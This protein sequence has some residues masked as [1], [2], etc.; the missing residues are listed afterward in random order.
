MRLPA[1]LTPDR[2]SRFGVL[3]LTAF[4]FAAAVAGVTYQL[5]GGLREEILR[6]EAE[7]LAGVASMQMANEMAKQAVLGVELPGKLLSAVLETSR[8]RGVIGVRVL[9]AQ[10]GFAGAQPYEWTDDLPAP[11]VWSRMI[12]DRPLA[13]LHR[14]ADVPSLQTLLMSQ[15]RSDPAVP[16]VEVWVP[17]RRPEGATLEGAA[18]FWMDGRDIAEE[19]AA[20]D[21]RLFGVAVA[22]W[23]AGTVLILAALL[24]AFNRLAL[25]NR[26]LRLR[27]DDLQ[28]ANRELVLAAKT[29]ALGAVTAH[30]IH[31]LKNPIAGLELFVANRSEPGARDG[32]GEE[33]EAATELTRRLR[34]MVNDVVAVLRDEQTGAQFEL[35]AE[36]VVEIALART[37][38]IAGE[39]QVHLVSHIET[40]AGIAARRG[41]LAALVLQNLLQNAVEA[42]AARGRVLVSSHANGAES[43]V[44]TV[45]DEGGG[46]PARVRERLFEPCTSTKAGGSGLGLALSHQLARQAGGRLELARTDATGTCFRLVLDSSA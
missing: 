24:W 31:A 40:Q 14:R 43:L 38:P 46:L 11:G 13:R 19:F 4:V 5:R 17:V 18:Q 33:L 34:H 8:L 42:T 6:R 23:G 45:E 3:L 29:S 7:L 16:L 2:A 22:A 30:L 27:T 41:N 1:F 44:F 10:R 37:R 28:R 15:A 26:E 12:A 36:E 20:V 21:R 32:Q 39:R 25:A 9:D 35:S